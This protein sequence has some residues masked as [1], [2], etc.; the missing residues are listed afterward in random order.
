MQTEMKETVKMYIINT[1]TLKT[2]YEL[3]IF[4]LNYGSSL[5][6]WHDA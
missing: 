4:R 5:Q 1:E 6:Y 2:Q 3:K